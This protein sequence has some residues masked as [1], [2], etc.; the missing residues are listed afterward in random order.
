MFEIYTHEFEL[1]GNT[2][3]LRPVTGKFLPLFYSIA[4][5]LQGSEDNNDVVFEEETISKLHTLV[6]ETF[7]VSYPDTNPE[8]LD[9]WVSQKLMKLIEPVLKVNTVSE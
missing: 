5:K 2:Y 4:G 9:A 7:K 6:L 8:E 3:K 1:E